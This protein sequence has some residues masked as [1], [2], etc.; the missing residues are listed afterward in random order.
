MPRGEY[1]AMLPNEV[2]MSPQFRWLPHFAVRVLLALAG[3]YR[4]K[5]NGALA[6]PLATAKEWGL[7]RAEL[8]AGLSLL[9]RVGFIEE[10]VPPRRKSGR[11]QP[12]RYALSWR[13][14]DE[15]PKFNLAASETVSKAWTAMDIATL[16]PR[17]RSL[18]NTERWRGHKR[19]GSWPTSKPSAHPTSVS[20]IESK[21]LEGVPHV[22]HERGGQIV[23][24]G[25]KTVTQFRTRRTKNRN[26]VLRA[27]HEENPKRNA[28]TDCSEAVTL[29]EACRACGA[30][31]DQKR[32]NARYCSDACRQR[33]YRNRHGKVAP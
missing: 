20:L 32:A 27:A 5:N 30:V 28:N 8:Y 2:G 23:T 18:R 25:P 7:S 16:G 13:K 24:R 1:Y 11:G 33:A 3:Q 22:P 21:S 19:Y 6:L 9:K 26:A 12:A 10:T 4:G 31:M 15:S 14:L 17:L 29:S